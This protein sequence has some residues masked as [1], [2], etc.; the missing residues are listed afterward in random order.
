MNSV[1]LLILDLSDDHMCYSLLMMFDVELVTSQSVNYVII[2]H[3]VIS[4]KHSFR[5]I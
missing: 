2:S 4:L 3:T 5:T 1:I